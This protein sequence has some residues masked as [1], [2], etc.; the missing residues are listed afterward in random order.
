MEKK[1]TGKRNEDY[2]EAIFLLSKTK[3]IIRIKDI[4]EKLKV[5]KSSVVSMIEKLLE[6]GFLIH[7][8]YGD[9]L[10]TQKGIEEAQKVYHKHVTF[11]SFLKD[12]LDIEEDIAEYD[13]CNLEHYVSDVTIEKLLKFVE[14]FLYIFDKNKVMF[15][16]LKNYFDTGEYPKTTKANED[17]IQK[18]SIL[19][20][21]T[22]AKVL[23][24]K[25]EDSIKNNFL[26]I[27]LV[28]GAEIEILSISVKM[29]TITV[30]VQDSTLT[31][32]KNEAKEVDVEIF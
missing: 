11:H 12:V 13:A 7:E 23:A 19:K 31:L 26:S 9:V 15:S 3:R 17:R 29:G 5:K 27:G 24:V 4:A 18:L 14:F 1:H 22:K 8:K 30:K 25:G 2:L 16:N 32:Q 6:D 20:T 28:P 21:G 10:L